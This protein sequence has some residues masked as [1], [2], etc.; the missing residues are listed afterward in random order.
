MSTDG[1]PTARV[2][3]W[4]PDGGHIGHAAMYIGNYEVGKNFELSL[5]P[6]SPHHVLPSALERRVGFQ[7]VH[8]N[9][10]YVSW[11][12][13]DGG[14]GVTSPKAGADPMLGLYKDV[15]AEHSEPHVVYDI[16]GLDVSAMRTAWRAARDKQGAHY[17]LY[18]KNCS[19]LVLRIL[20]AGRALSKLSA[21]TA[22]WFGHNAL[23]TPKKVAQLC[24]EL[25][26]AGWALKT[27]AGNCPSKA[28]CGKLM[29][30]AGLR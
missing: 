26:D 20:V 27:K 1:V 22:A 2:F 30:I 17:Q 8:Y 15:E 9:D 10:N 25:R 28:D 16:Y 21:L 7:G 5:D 11:W 6:E 19:D 4:Y 14:A 29:V 3:I 23:T 13:D 12:P 18:R 24:N